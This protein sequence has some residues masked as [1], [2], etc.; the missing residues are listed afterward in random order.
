MARLYRAQPSD[1]AAWVTGASKGIGRSVALAL[2]RAGYRVAA[3]A[4]DAALLADVVTQAAGLPGRI[5][6]F[7]CDV[8]DEAA[9]AQTVAA[10]EAELGPIVLALFNAGTYFPARGDALDVENFRKAYDINVFGVIHGLVPTVERMHARGYGQMALMASATAYGGLPMAAAYGAT[11]AALNNMA[12]ALKF[13]FDKMNIRIQVINPGFVET[14]LT[15]KNNFVMPALMPVDAAAARIVAG[16][17]GGGFEIAFPRR[18]TLQ[19][20]LLR[21]LPRALYF[22]ILNR[23]LGWRRRRVR[24]TGGS[25]RSAGRR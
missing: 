10:I 8:T 15:H 12:E 4:R 6:A 21:L 5:V 18:F 11:K 20:K 25:G 19:L 9:M 22:S 2:A 3:S 24:G 7:P 16:L 17:A 23:R 13:D 1:G 14:P